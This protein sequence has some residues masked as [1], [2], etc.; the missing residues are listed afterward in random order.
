MLMSS[1]QLCFCPQVSILITQVEE[2]ILS[3]ESMNKYKS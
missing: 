3:T 2:M 1:N